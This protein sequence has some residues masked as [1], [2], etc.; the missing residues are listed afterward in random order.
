MQKRTFGQVKTELRRVAGATGMQATDERL[1]ELTFLAQERLCTLGQWPF[2]YARVKFRQFDDIVSLPS[3]YEALVHTTLDDEPLDVQPSWFEFLEFGPGST[4][5]TKW[6]TV[7]IDL[8]ESPVFR[9]PG[10]NAGPVRV[11]SVNGD[12]SG[13]VVLTGLDG[14]GMSQTEALALPEA[15]S[16]VRWSKLVQVT[17]P[18]TTGDVVLSLRTDD[19]DEVLLASY[20]GRDT[21]PTFRTY[22]FPVQQGT[23]KTV[24]A[25]VRRRL[26]PILSDN[27]ELFVTNVG[28]LRLGVKAIALEDAG[29][30]GDAAGTFDLAASILSAEAK[31]YK[32]T[33]ANPGVNVS[34]VASMTTRPDIF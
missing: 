23:G 27:D 4:E 5:K 18:V 19:G 29:K 16:T 9:Q 17:K 12:D 30:I 11:V 20:R 24:R 8:G 1:R 28:A 32:E 26:Y 10:A 13:N 14:N 21:N 22:R 3:E 25:I 6:A 33:R 31:L 2:Q 7:G 15:I 34:R